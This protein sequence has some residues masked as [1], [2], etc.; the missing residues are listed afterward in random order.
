[1]AGADASYMH[2][3]FDVTK[4]AGD[5][6]DFTLSL[7]Y[8]DNAPASGGTGDLTPFVSWSKSF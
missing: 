1:M 2:F 3:Q 8:A 6:G 7:S 5:Y 4:S